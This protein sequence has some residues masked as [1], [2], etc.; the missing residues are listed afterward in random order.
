MVV[1]H[2][3]YCDQDEPERVQK[4][5]HNGSN[6]ITTPWPPGTSSSHRIC[7]IEFP[8]TTHEQIGDPTV[9]DGILDRL[10]HNVEN[11]EIV[12]TGTS[13]TVEEAQCAA[14]HYG[15][16]HSFGINQGLNQQVLAL[17]LFWEPR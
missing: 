2:A 15:I 11:C 1:H 13:P 3:G 9:A 16:V 7:Q 6:I 17:I 8:D 12:E 14:L 5:D 4:A 10:V